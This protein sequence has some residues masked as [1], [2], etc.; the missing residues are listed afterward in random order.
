MAN[1]YSPKLVELAKQVPPRTLDML[2]AGR[3]FYYRGEDKAGNFYDALLCV[4]VEERP[5]S[6]VC[7]VMDPSCHPDQMFSRF[8]PSNFLTVFPLANDC[9]LV[10]G[11]EDE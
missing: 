9:D 8:S 5:C 10:Q 11:V 1:E 6:R 4:V 2:G 7:Q 3:F